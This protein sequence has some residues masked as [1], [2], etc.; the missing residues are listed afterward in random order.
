MS[1]FQRTRHMHAT[2][3]LGC[4]RPMPQ[5]RMIPNSI[6]PVL[7]PYNPST[8][9]PCM[10]RPGRQRV[11]N[12]ARHLRADRARR[13]QR[14]SS[15]GSTRSEGCSAVSSALT[16]R[17]V[18]RRTSLALGAPVGAHGARHG[19]VGA[20]AG[21]GAGAGVGG[22]VPSHPSRP[23]ASSHAAPT[24]PA[25]PSPPRQCTSRPPSTRAT[26]RRTPKARRRR[27]S[28][29]GA[30]H[31]ACVHARG[32]DRGPGIC[33]YARRRGRR[34]AL[35]DLSKPRRA[36]KDAA[37]LS[38]RGSSIAAGDRAETVHQ[39]APLAPVTPWANG[40]SGTCAG[41][42]PARRGI[43]CRGVSSSLRGPAPTRRA[44][45]DP[46]GASLACQRAPA[47]RPRVPGRSRHWYLARA[48]LAPRTRM[49]ACRR[50]RRGAWYRRAGVALGSRE[51]ATAGAQGELGDECGRDVEHG[52]GFAPRGS[53]RR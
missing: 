53:T 45:R 4:K 41:S 7:R 39:P 22:S 48:A 27:G 35:R 8:P 18:S 23:S 19:H 10:C 30:R 52:R 5:P 50:A 49:C 29:R 17:R 42:T 28:R 38:S 40:G 31:R 2:Y 43:S 47:V 16:L 25:R 34:A 15:T 14:R 36:G 33:P 46:G 9:R 32:R 12:L 20:G 44:R 24:S 3:A 37:N 51:R 21:A 1:K 11:R 6:S 13:R 26:P